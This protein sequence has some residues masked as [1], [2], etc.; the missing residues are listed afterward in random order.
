MII[1]KLTKEA[2]ELAVQW[3]KTRDTGIRNQ[4]YEKVK[5]A[6]KYVPEEQEGNRINFK[7]R[8]DK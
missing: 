3:K 1:D 7:G 4:W 5:E 2:D 6:A 8:V